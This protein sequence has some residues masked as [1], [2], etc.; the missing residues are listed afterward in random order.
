MVGWQAGFFAQSPV[1]STHYLSIDPE[2]ATLYTHLS[3]NRF[4]YTLLETN[5]Y[6]LK[7]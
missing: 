5:P 6:L 1:L 7:C 4:P 2:A 3:L